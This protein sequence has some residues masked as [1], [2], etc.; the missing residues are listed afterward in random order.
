[1]TTTTVRSI[2]A[3]ILENHMQMDDEIQFRLSCGTYKI[4][5]GDLE[6]TWVQTDLNRTE[7]RKHKRLEFVFDLD[8]VIEDN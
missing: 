4:N 2:L 1:M 5:K 6:I 7:D 3:M 8:E